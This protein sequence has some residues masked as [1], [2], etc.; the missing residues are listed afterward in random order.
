MKEDASVTVHVNEFN[1]ILSY[2]VSVD[3]IYDGE[4]QALLLLSAVPESWSNTVIIVRTSSSSLLS[5]GRKM[6]GVNGKTGARR[7]QRTCSRRTRRISCLENAT[8]LDPLD[9]SVKSSA[10]EKE[11]NYVP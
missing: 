2:L 9:L 6:R 7:N 8:R 3:N 1:S 5:V 11:I 10:Q 4:V